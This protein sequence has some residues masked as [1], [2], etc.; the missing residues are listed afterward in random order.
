MTDKTKPGA[1]LASGHRADYLP[2]R[3][4]PAKILHPAAIFNA[5][6]AAKQL[7]HFSSALLTAVLLPC[8]RSSLRRVE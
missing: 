5:P 7:A 2:A 1:A 8:G 3:T 6:L 4:S